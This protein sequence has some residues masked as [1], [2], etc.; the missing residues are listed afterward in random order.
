MFLCIFAGSAG[1]DQEPPAAKNGMNRKVAAKNPI[2]P[3]ISGDYVRQ[4][5]GGA[6]ARRMKKQ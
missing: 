1:N 4:S 2:E 5:D 3:V 6:H